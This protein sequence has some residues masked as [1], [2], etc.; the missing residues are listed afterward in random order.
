MLDNRVRRLAC[1]PLVVFAGHAMAPTGSTPAR[2]GR[3]V[4]GRVSQVGST[5]PVPQVLVRVNGTAIGVMTGEKGCTNSA[6]SRLG[7]FSSSFGT[8][9]TSRSR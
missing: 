1:I 9:V 5:V 6:T 3:I 7:Q 2:A 8:H 4:A